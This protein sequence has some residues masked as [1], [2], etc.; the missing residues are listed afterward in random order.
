MEKSTKYQ[1]YFQHYYNIVIEGVP[2]SVT[3]DYIQIT[4]MEVM[5]EI[6]SNEIEEIKDLC[7]QL[8]AT[9]V[10]SALIKVKNTI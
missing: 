3:Y 1:Q 8:R 9:R 10:L 7:H 5:K 6:R 4:V 2:D